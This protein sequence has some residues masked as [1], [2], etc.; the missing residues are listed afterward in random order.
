MDGLDNRGEIVI[1]GATNRIENIDPALRRPGRFDREFPFFL[2]NRKTRKEII[3][4]KGVQEI[5]I[6]LNFAEEVLTRP[7]L[8][9]L[10]V[11]KLNN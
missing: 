11:P 5:T 9:H 1:I 2:P 10:S 4:I 6:L 8:K 7:N 3:K